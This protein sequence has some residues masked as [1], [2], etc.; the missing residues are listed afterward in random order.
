MGV[1]GKKGHLSFSIATIGTVCVGLN[2]FP[3]SGGFFGGDGTVFA[4][5]DGLDIRFRW[6]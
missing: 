3:D 4:H 1:C 2:E 5:R 6:A